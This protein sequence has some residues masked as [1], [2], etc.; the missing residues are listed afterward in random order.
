MIFSMT[1]LRILLSATVLTVILV[2][3]AYAERRV[4]RVEDG[5]TVEEEDD[6]SR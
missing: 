1:T 5:I 6:A 2:T 3:P 4:E